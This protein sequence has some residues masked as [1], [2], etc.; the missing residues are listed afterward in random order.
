MQHVLLKIAYYGQEK[1]KIKASFT[2]QILESR[3]LALIND[4]EYKLQIQL[5]KQ[6]CI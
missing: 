3:E 2:G 4:S 6:T 1:S 5:P